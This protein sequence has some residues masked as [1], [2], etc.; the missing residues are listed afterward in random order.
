VVG[1]VVAFASTACSVSGTMQ[2]GNGYISQ[3][4]PV[5]TFKPA[6]RHTAPNVS[7]EA[8]DG[9]HLSLQ[10]Y[11][12]KVVVVNVW[13][14]WCSPCR[15]EANDL[16]QAYDRL[17]GAAFLGID[18]NEDTRSQPIAFERAH[19]APYQSIYD[20]DG[21]VLLSF[22]G[23]VRPDSLPSTLVIDPQG[24]IAALVNGPVDTTTLVGLVHDVQAES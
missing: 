15:G 18:T 4:G 13:A 21:S 3:T 23:L 12:G 5:V 9:T 22:Y 7:G 19:P 1:A 6:D 20:A 10:D 14:S 16:T 17:P 8:L 2:G 24:R 11:L